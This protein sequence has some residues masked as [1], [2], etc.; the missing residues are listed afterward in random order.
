MPGKWGDRGHTYMPLDLAD[1]A[2]VETALR[3]AWR[4][5]APNQLAATL[6]PGRED[7]DSYARRVTAGRRRP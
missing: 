3:A 5:A 7:R 4:R 6:D 1:A 2:A